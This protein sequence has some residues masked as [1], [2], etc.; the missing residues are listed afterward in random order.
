MEVPHTLKQYEA[1]LSTEAIFGRITGSNIFSKV[2]L[3]HSFCLILLHS[4]DYTEFVLDKVLY[5]FK[6]VRYG[7]Q[8]SRYGL[9]WTLHS[10]LNK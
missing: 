1:P 2:E 8:S 9:V 3:K 4:R 7:L 6:V 10:I 5:G